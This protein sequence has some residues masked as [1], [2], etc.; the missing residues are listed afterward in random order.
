LLREA[1]TLRGKQNY[2]LPRTP[3]HAVFATRE[4]QRLQTFKERSRLEHHALA[5]AE[6]AVIHGAVLVMRELSQI[7][8]FD[9]R[10]AHLA[11]PAG[12]PVI[13]R[14]AEEAGENG[15]NIGFHRTKNL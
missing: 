1:L 5:A 12:D 6:G 2:R 14:S 8:D 11:G 15:E 13:Q 4:L 3:R 9:F 7:V 10:Q